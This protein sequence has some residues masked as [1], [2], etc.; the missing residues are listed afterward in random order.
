MIIPEDRFDYL[1]ILEELF[2]NLEGR[3]DS[4]NF[5][6]L[7]ST[8]RFSPC[9]NGT[10]ALPNSFPC[11]VQKNEL[12]ARGLVGRLC[13]DQLGF[14]LNFLGMV[15]GKGGGGVYGKKSK[16]VRNS[17]IGLQLTRDHPICIDGCYSTLSNVNSKYKCCY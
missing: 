3:Y 8:L 7:T 4:Q 5:E 14:L 13:F 2:D 11:K 12:L 15:W 17:A 10:A 6:P 1:L 9:R 16:I